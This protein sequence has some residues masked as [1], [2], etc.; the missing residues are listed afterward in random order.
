MSDQA[1]K[2]FEA[3]SD[4]D[5]ELL[6]RCDQK[7]ARKNGSAYRLFQRY[8]RAVAAGICLMVAGAVSW[9]GYL[10]V[11]FEAGADSSSN[12]APAESF[13]MTQS[14]AVEDESAS[15][16]N[17]DGGLENN[18]A[19]GGA[20]SAAGIAEDKETSVK[21]REPAQGAAPAQAESGSA[22]ADSTEAVP[23]AVQQELAQSQTSAD[24]IDGVTSSGTGNNMT[25]EENQVD[26]YADLRKQENELLDARKEIL[27]EEACT[28]EPFG[29][30][31][32]TVLPAGYEAFSARR[33][34]FPEQWDNM[35]FKWTD[36]EHIFSLDMTQGEAVTRED[37]AQRDGLHEYVAEDFRKELILDPLEGEPISFTLYYGDGM[38][39]DFKG[40]ITADEMCEVVESIKR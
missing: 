4:V 17:G 14:L 29:S 18:T 35:I 21:E 8:G 28:T 7:A 22:A 34:F 10:L 20:E 16:L 2:I 9:G 31:L 39:I 36:G 6:E 19:G 37:I 26:Q 13:Q 24:K 32:P 30:Y 1:V 5:E 38:R 3:L 40:Y 33:G 11:T 25:E 27:W 23:E 15:D 12:G